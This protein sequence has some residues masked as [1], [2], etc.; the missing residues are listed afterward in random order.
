MERKLLIYDSFTT[1]VFKGN[2]AGV[3]LGA[4]GLKDE[5]MQ[6]IAKE[7]GYP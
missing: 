4:D 1:E 2:P 7:L 3:L 6:N 5:E